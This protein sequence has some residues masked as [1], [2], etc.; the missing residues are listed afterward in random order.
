MTLDVWMH[1]LWLDAP[2]DLYGCSRWPSLLLDVLDVYQYSSCPLMHQ[3]IFIDAQDDPWYSW[4][5]WMSI[6]VQV[7]PWCTNTFYGCS[8]WPLIQLDAQDGPRLQL[9]VPGCILMYLVTQLDVPWCILMYLLVAWCTWMQL[10]V[11]AWGWV[12]I[13][14]LDVPGWY[15]MLVCWFVIEIIT[16]IWLYEWLWPLSFCLLFIS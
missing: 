16:M 10:D 6:D 15:L 4:M 3:N 2:R 11:L 12:E 7:V 13:L 5:S 1:K 9:N 14:G 8:R